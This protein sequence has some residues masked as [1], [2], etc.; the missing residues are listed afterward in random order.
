M[1]GFIFMDLDEATLS[2][3]FPTITF[4]Q[5]KKILNV[6]NL[7]TYHTNSTL[8]TDLVSLPYFIAAPRSLSFLLLC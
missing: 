6:I 4:G 7:F 5:R 3:E 8:D 1:D 2:K